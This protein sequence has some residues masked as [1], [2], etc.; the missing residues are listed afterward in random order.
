MTHYSVELRGELFVKGYESLSFA[1]NMRKNIG[2]NKSKNLSSK[3]SLKLLDQAKQSAT[4]TLKTVS[5]IAIQKTA[6]A[7]G[8]LIGKL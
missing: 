7:I 5:K 6:E 8:S 4:D 3:C 1:R 2:K